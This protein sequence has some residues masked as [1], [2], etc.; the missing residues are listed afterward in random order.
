[1]SYPVSYYFTNC[2]IFSHLVFFNW[3]YNTFTLLTIISNFRSL[4]PS[5]IALD[6]ISQSR[7]SSQAFESV[8]I[9]TVLERILDELC[10]SNLKTSMD[11]DSNQCRF[12]QIRLEYHKYLFHS[13]IA[14]EFNR[15]Q[16]RGPRAIL[17]RWH[18]LLWK[19]M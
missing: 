17:R 16:K 7:K 18:K 3:N 1:M 6:S 14:T 19:N 11:F 2:L 10:L 13:Q 5:T 12:I 4:K 15:E 8:D 9:V